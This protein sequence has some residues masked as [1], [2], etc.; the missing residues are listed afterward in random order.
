[1]GFDEKLKLL[2]K[3]EGYTQKKFAELLESSEISIRNYEAGRKN[4]NGKFYMK[5]CKIFPEYAYWITTGRIDPP[6]HIDP[7]I[8]SETEVQDNEVG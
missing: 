1:M 4:P 3:T 7:Y 2:R 8:K 6:K 5:L